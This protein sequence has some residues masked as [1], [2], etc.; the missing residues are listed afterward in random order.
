MLRTEKTAHISL[1]HFSPNKIIMIQHHPIWHSFHDKQLLPNAKGAATKIRPATQSP[2]QGKP[3]ADW[4]LA[5]KAG[6]PI[7]G[8]PAIWRSG[9][10]RSVFCFLFSVYRLLFSVYRLRLYSLLFTL[11][12]P[13]FPVFRS[14]AQLPGTLFRHCFFQSQDCS[15]VAIN[16]KFIFRIIRIKV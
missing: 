4:L 10:R 15:V 9:G 12:S 5:K 3:M 16:Q 1:R 11:N 8:Y 14:E 13:L 2:C 7:L 6:Q